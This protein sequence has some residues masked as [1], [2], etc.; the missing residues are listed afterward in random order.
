MA[1]SPPPSFRLSPSAANSC[2]LHSP[3]P[4]ALRHVVP[5][6]VEDR[7]WSELIGSADAPASTGWDRSL[8][9]QHGHPN[10]RA[11]TPGS[12]QVVPGDGR[13]DEHP[14]CGPSILAL[15]GTNWLSLVESMRANCDLQS[16]GESAVKRN[17]DLNL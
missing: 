13:P 14:L 6:V 9:A 5:T 2:G 10:Y 17:P 16:G 3:D 8:V 1:G 7:A 11:L 4:A 12:T 15:Q